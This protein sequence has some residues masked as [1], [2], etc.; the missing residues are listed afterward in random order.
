MSSSIVV[1]RET[2]EKRWEVANFKMGSAVTVSSREVEIYEFN[3]NDFKKRK[4]NIG[5][6]RVRTG[7]L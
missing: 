4:K 7:D 3:G 5:A 1:F 6:D 2:V